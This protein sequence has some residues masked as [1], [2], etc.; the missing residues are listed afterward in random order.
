MTKTDSLPCP[1]TIVQVN[2]NNFLLFPC[3]ANALKMTNAQKIYEDLFQFEF[4]FESS[5]CCYKPV[6][7]IK[8]D[9]FSAHLWFLPISLQA[10][11]SITKSYPE[12]RRRFTVFA[13]LTLRC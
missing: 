10:A 6:I 4:S 7:N 13:T 5:L 1:L 11:R 2:R 8:L 3:V 9:S 12:E